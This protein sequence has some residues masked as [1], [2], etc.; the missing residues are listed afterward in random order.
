MPRR[1]VKKALYTTYLCKRDEAE[2]NK[3][4]T[5]LVGDVRSGDSDIDP[6]QIDVRELCHG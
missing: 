1:G 5:Y 3:E 4:Y 2:N 6:Y